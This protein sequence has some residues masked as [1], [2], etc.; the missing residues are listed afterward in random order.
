[1]PS[2][3]LWIS[4]RES[5]RQS[6]ARKQRHLDELRDTAECSHGGYVVEEDASARE[7]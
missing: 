6:R 4:N 7:W 5:T 3:Q 2:S 1:L